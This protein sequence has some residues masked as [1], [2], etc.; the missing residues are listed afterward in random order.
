MVKGAY[1]DPLNMISLSKTGIPELER[2]RSEVTRIPSKANA[3]GL[4]QIMS[5]EEM[6]RLGIE[7]PNMADSLMMSQFIAPLEEEWVKPKVITRARSASRYDR[8]NRARR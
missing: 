5:K 4:M 1:V 8:Q 3:H 6:L 7:S 2:L